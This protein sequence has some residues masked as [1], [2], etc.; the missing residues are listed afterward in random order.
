MWIRFRP[1]TLRSAF[2]YLPRRRATLHARMRTTVIKHADRRAGSS[3]FPAP[4]NLRQ[5]CLIA[6]LSEVRIQRSAVVEH[7]DGCRRDP[8][9]PPHWIWAV[10]QIAERTPVMRVHPAPTTMFR[11]VI[12]HVAALAER[13]QL[14]K[15]VVAWVM[16]EMSACEHHR[17]PFAQAQ[18][19]LRWPTNTPTVAIAP[20]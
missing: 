20:V 15:R 17:R 1:R 19:V 16:I 3:P 18:Y 12:D 7:A 9:R 4:S 11:T 2:G 8:V 13:R 14:M 5:Q 10:E 6:E